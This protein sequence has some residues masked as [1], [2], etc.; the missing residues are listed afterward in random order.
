MQQAVPFPKKDGTAFVLP[1]GV[2]VVGA[3][4]GRLPITDRVKQA[5]NG[6]PYGHTEKS[7]KHKDLFSS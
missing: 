2:L 5:T 3:T 6:R 4:I 7:P 1:F